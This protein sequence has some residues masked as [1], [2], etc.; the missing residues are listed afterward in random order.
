MINTVLGLFIGKSFIVRNISDM[1]Y[2]SFTVY[3]KY[4]NKTHKIIQGS[5]RS[6]KMF[7]LQQGV[8]GKERAV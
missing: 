8:N 6:F 4:L 1:E 5:R 3:T 7:H 2:S